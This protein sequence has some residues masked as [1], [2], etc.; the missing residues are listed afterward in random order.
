MECTRGSCRSSRWEVVLSSVHNGEAVSPHGPQDA[1]KMGTRVHIRERHSQWG[2]HSLWGE[3]SNAVVR[4]LYNRVQHLQ[5]DEAFTK[6]GSSLQQ[7][8]P[9]FWANILNERFN[10]MTKYS[11]AIGR[12][13]HN[14][15]K[16]SQWGETC[17]RGA[18]RQSCHIQH[19]MI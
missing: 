12:R 5:W 14:G 19:G 9:T 11:T 15:E 2:M 18:F 6:G 7:G 16:P 1:F 17:A 3:A 10:L 13:T 4:P 8:G